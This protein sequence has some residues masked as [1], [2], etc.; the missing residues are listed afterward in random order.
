M[1]RF[2]LKRGSFEK[3]VEKELFADENLFAIK[4][5]TSI[6]N[7]YIPLTYKNILRLIS[8][9]YFKV[10]SY[11]S[12]LLFDI[13]KSRFKNKKLRFRLLEIVYILS[14]FVSL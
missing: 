4:N 14:T 5:C 13:F 10:Q 6:S 3:L 8:L 7:Q 1:E 12:L 2:F 11:F 9:L